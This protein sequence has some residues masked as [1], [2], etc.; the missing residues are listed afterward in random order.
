L[1]DLLPGA[2]F[3]AFVAFLGAAFDAGFFFAACFFAAAGRAPFAAPALFTA[4]FD[5]CTAKAPP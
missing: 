1:I 5:E 2:L 3:R 4:G